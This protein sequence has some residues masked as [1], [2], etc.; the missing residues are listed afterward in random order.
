MTSGETDNIT[1]EYLLNPV[2]Q[3][4]IKRTKNGGEDDENSSKKDVKFYRKRINALSRDIMRGNIVNEYV[5][6]AHREYVNAAI[7]YFQMN[8]RSEILQNEYGESSATP[9]VEEGS[10]TA[11]DNFSMGRANEVLF[12]KVNAPP[13]LDNF[14]TSK[15]VKMSKDIKHP[16]RRQIN[17]KTQE[18]RFKGLHAKREKQSKRENTTIKE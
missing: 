17:L 6:N 3:S 13:T 15:T 18:L 14:V 8:D 5:A 1:L 10:D 9:K 12:D 11:G 7:H 2:Y 4:N 16:Q